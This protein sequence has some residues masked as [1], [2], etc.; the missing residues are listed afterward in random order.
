MSEIQEEVIT[1]EQPLE[2]VIEEDVES[3][4]TANNRNKIKD[5]NS[6]PTQE[7]YMISSNN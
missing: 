3:E 6:L 5:S 7:S 1:E 4:D 2:E